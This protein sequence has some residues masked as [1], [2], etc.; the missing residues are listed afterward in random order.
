MIERLRATGAGSIPA[1]DTKI[2][3]KKSKNIFK[4]IIMNTKRLS[5]DGNAGMKNQT[6]C[7]AFGYR[8]NEIKPKNPKIDKLKNN[9]TIPKF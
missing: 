4:R 9:K 7:L 3:I 6:F 5:N 1:A 2:K 8:F